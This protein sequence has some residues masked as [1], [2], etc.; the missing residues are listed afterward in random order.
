KAI[1]KNPSYI[2]VPFFI[3]LLF[4]FVFFIVYNFFLGNIMKKVISLLMLT[5]ES[6]QGLTQANVALNVLSNQQQMNS[7]IINIGFWIGGLAVLTYAIYCISQGIN[8]FIAHKMFKIKT[9]PAEYVKRFFTLNFVWYLIVMIII[10]FYVKAVI[11][12]QVLRTPSNLGTVSVFSLMLVAVICY[13]AFI[14]YALIKKY[15]F[16]DSIKKSFSLATKEFS[17]IACM[18]ILFILGFVLIDIILKLIFIISTTLMIIVGII[19]IFPVIAYMR[20]VIISVVED[21]TKTK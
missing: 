16:I 4:L 9:K 12:T 6:L 2:V 3:D 11:Y 21:L 14:S 5:G 19:L 7:L 17:T 18:Y 15:G 1:R 13:F 8:W 10:Y 20:L